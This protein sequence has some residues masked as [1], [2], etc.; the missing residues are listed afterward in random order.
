MSY[1]AQARSDVRSYVKRPT[2][3]STLDEVGMLT[4]VTMT[5]LSLK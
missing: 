1:D 2:W 4:V 3:G 5:A